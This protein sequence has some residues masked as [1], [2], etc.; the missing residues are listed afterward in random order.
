MSLLITEM[1]IPRRDLAMLSRHRKIAVSFRDNALLPMFSTAIDFLKSLLETG[2]V[3]ILISQG[4]QL[5]LEQSSKL[6]ECT[7][8]VIENCLGFDFIGTIPDDSSDD[9]G[10][11]QIP[12]SW[13]HL[14]CEFSTIK[15]FFDGFKACPPS[16][17]SFVCFM[18][19]LICSI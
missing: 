7:L 18:I 3:L 11:I 13:K 12:A 17:S 14:I 15:L 4:S 10:T 1:N 8:M 9:I 6:Q 5:P 19:L 2:A 16:V